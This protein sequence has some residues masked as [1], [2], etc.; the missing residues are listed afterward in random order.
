MKLIY[1]GSESYTKLLGLLIGHLSIYL[2]PEPIVVEETQ[3]SFTAGDDSDPYNQT[4]VFEQCIRKA[5]PDGSHIQETTITQTRTTF[6]TSSPQPQYENEGVDIV[7]ISDEDEKLFE[8][9]SEPERPSSIRF[10]QD[11]D[12]FEKLEQELR[13][14][15]ENNIQVAQETVEYGK[16]IVDEIIADALS[17]LNIEGNGEASASEQE[18]R[19]ESPAP[20]SPVSPLDDSNSY[21]FSQSQPSEEVSVSEEA[22]VVVPLEAEPE[23][24]PEEQQPEPEGER[25]E[26]EP[27]AAPTAGPPKGK[28]KKKKK[29]GR[30]SGGT[31]GQ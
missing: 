17:T 11:L 5:T 14:N 30:A 3:S 10:D 8:P 18:P 16:E 15:Q 22:E 24:V 1:V 21:S 25:A 4:Q 29:G 9:E 26:A 12:D 13:E 27:V 20:Q 6:S 31:E 28:K 23:I 2:I 7:E 19:E